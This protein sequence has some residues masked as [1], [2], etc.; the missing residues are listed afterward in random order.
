MED[1]RWDIKVTSKGQITVPKEV[2][3]LLMVREG[4][5]LQ[6]VV[7][8]NAIVLTRKVEMGDSEKV[9]LVAEQVLG[10]LGYG[11]S[12]SGKSVPDRMLLRDKVGVGHP[13]LTRLVR[14][15]RDKE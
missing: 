1:S 4:D 9:R 15:G 8:D 12:G 7:R 3:E 6:A 11:A 10:Q 2:R 14:L 5:Y 13:D